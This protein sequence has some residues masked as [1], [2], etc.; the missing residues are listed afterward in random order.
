MQLVFSNVFD[1][2]EVTVFKKCAEFYTARLGNIE[3]RLN[4]NYLQWNLEWFEF[5]DTI[6]CNKFYWCA[7]NNC[8]LD[9]II[10]SEYCFNCP[11]EIIET[12]ATQA[13]ASNTHTLISNP[14]TIDDVR[15]NIL[16]DY[17]SLAH[18]GL[19][20]KFLYKILYSTWIY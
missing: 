14:T 16:Y 6:K 13:S 2:K 11:K 17:K 1:I 10:N 18:N 19:N 9:K 20:K 8:S 4:F 3:L 7:Y 5:I 15:K 12:V